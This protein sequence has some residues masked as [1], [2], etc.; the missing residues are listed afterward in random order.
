VHPLVAAAIVILGALAVTFYAFNQGLPFVH[1]FSVYAL[2][3]NSVN[4]RGGDP[5]RIAGVNVGEVSSVTDAGNASRIELALDRSALPVHRDATIRIR[6][7]LFLEGSYYLELDP[8]TPAAPVLRDGGTLPE[9]QTSSPVQFYKLLSTFTAPVRTSLVNLVDALDEGLGSP[10]GRSLRGS[11]AAALKQVAPQLAPL[12]SD[13]AVVT[14]SLRGTAPGDVGTV[15]SSTANVTGTLA[16][17]SAQLADLVRGLGE[18]ASALASSDGALARTI[19]GVDQT[20]QATPA[21]L[22]AVDR[23]LPAVRSLARALEPS[24]HV[25][26]PILD[27]LTATASQLAAVLAPRARGPLVQSLRVTF[28][29]LPAI[30]T[31]F[32]RAFPIGR[33]IT[34]CLRTHVLPVLSQTVPDGT[35]ST[36]RPVWQ[37]FVHFLPGVGGAS[38][39]FDANGPYTRFLA[40]AGTDTLSGAFGAQ[41]LVSTPPP[42]GS[43]LEGA[44]P[45]WI[46]ELTPSDFRPDVPCATQKLPSLASATAAP[47]LNLAGSGA[48]VAPRGKRSAR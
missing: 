1:R 3:S 7:R 40:G 36:G 46:G 29:Q 21:A 31:Q 11:G 28:Q 30:L 47:D 16:R 33:Q 35:L 42:G 23:S 25:A 10:P 17:S 48:P 9:S 8:G 24:L 19:A 34:D 39:S 4:V 32:A 6:D 13:T 12:L 22:S 26:P 14:R 44:R 37:D 41:Q 18:S 20:L 5:V 27:G 43:S 2:V 38:G 15:L 45:R